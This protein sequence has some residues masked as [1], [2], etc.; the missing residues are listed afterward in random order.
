MMCMILLLVVVLLLSYGVSET[1]TRLHI[2]RQNV[3]KDQAL[4][5]A[6]AGADYGAEML[7]ANSSYTGTSKVSYGA[8]TFS[9]TVATSTVKSV[10]TLPDGVSATVCVVC[11]G[12]G[13]SGMGLPNG[14]IV[15]NGNV[16]MSGQGNTYTSPS[17]L[18]QASVES[19][20]NITLSGQPSVDGVVSAHGTASMS[21]QGTAYGGLVSGASLIAFPSASQLSTWQTQLITTAKTGTV[22]SATSLTKS[23]TWTSPVYVNGNLSL[24]GQ[25][26]LT[27]TG[28]GVV[29]VNGTISLSGQSELINSGIL[30]SAG[31]MSASGQTI[32]TIGSN[33]NAATAL[34]SFA[35]S[36]SAITIS[37]QGVTNPLGMVYA[38]NGGI[39]L[40]GQGNVYGSLIAG[41]TGGTG[42]VSVSGQGGIYYLANLNA[43][44]T[45]GPSSSWSVASWVE[46]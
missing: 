8:G 38:A 44:S 33:S 24:S 13:S 39:S 23:T 22:L 14:A 29:Y 12:G 42:T 35:S 32:Y 19:N 25:C 45:I 5:I 31:A 21:G 37:G 2:T 3:E 41:G 9:V 16:T 6:E 18:H 1:T 20:G 34:V 10:G 28:G 30:A 40:S 7:K 26:T 27:I 17:T 36:S 43:N 11:S 46:M 4:C 15:A